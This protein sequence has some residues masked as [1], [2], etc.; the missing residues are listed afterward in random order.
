[1]VTV[2]WLTLTAAP[3]AGEEGDPEGRDG[4]RLRCDRQRWRRQAGNARTT[5][6]T[7]AA[8]A[9]YRRDRNPHDVSRRG[10]G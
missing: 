6:R 10:V 4:N 1:M 9:D 2:E 8:A 5:T 3:A 7:P